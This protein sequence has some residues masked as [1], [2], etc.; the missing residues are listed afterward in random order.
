MLS[1]QTTPEF[2]LRFAG[3]IPLTESGKPTRIDLQD[4][5]PRVDSI[6]GTSVGSVENLEELTDEASGRQ[7]H[8]F[9]VV[10]TPGAENSLS[11]LDLVVDADNDAGEVRELR[12]RFNITTT[13]LEAAGFN[14]PAPVQEPV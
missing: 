7:Y 5:P 10:T 6:T 9:D 11:E 3:I 4:A 13:A 14:A 2:K 12:L 1:G 8:K